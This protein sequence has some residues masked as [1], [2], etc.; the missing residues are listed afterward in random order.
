MAA[1]EILRLF[2]DIVSAY[3]V[4]N[5]KEDWEDGHEY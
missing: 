1:V 3:V 2:N 4:I 5:R